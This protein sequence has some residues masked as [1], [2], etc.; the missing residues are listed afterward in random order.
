MAPKLRAAALVAGVHDRTLRHLATIARR[1]NGATEVVIVR[2]LVGQDGETAQFLEDFAAERHRR[3]ETG[4]GH[5]E[6]KAGQHI[7]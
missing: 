7:G 3:A 5:T 1:A 4:I 6:P 2:Q